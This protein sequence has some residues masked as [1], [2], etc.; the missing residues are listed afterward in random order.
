MKLSKLLLGVG[1]SLLASSA[2]AVDGYKDLK[3]GSSIEQVKKS[4]SCKSGWI[5]LKQNGAWGCPKFQFGKDTTYGYAFLFDNKLERVSIMIPTGKASAVSNGLLEKYG[6]P[7]SIPQNAPTDGNFP[8]NSNWD[9]GFDND[10]VLFRASFDANGGQS[11]F[12]IYTTTD[13]NKKAQQNQNFE[14]KDDL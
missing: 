4:K 10:T 5:D 9:V 7:S 14:V 13:F 6:Q 3:F 2:L 1:V 11:S 8:P 12:V